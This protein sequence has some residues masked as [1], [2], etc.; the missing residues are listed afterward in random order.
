[1]KMPPTHMIGAVTRTVAVIWTSTWICWTSLVV[2][3]SSEG[4]PNRA[5]SRS[6][7]VVT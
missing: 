1:M 7:N 5:V 4:A 3:V 6:E 2:R